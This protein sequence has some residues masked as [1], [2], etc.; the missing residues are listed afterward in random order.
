ML[1]VMR[2]GFIGLTMTA[3]LSASAYDDASYAADNNRSVEPV[4][5]LALFALSY[6]NESDYEPVHYRSYRYKRNHRRGYRRHNSRNYG[7]R[8]GYRKRGYYKGGRYYRG[9]KRYYRRRY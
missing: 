7:Y 3:T 4:A 1:N 9:N 6:A 5:Q 2:L 8:H